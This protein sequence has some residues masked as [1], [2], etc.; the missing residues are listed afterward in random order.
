MKSS[1]LGAIGAFVALVLVVLAW[2]SLYVVGQ[3]Q[4]ALP[5][6]LGEPLQPKLE[7]GL[8]AKV[9][10]TDNIVFVDKRILDLDTPTLEVIAYDKKRLVVDAFTR[11]RVTDPLAFYQNYRL[12]DVAESRMNDIINSAVRSV[13]AQAPFVDVVRTRRNELMARIKSEVNKQMSPNGI[14]IVD[15]RIRRADLPDA[16]SQAVFERMKT[17][18]AQEA[19]QYR[20]E[21][22]QEYQRLRAEADR[23]VS[24]LLG[25]ANG[26][27]ANIRGDADAQRTHIF[28]DAYGRDT[29]FFTFYRSLQAYT[30][31]LKAGQTRFVLR[32][33]SEFFRYLFPKAEAAP[34]APAPTVPSAP[35]Q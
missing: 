7:P 8:Y 26:A 29:E 22:L 12:Q 19:A 6:R 16:N 17:E 13:L 27:A 23:Q 34:A 32:P 30:D 10:F 33:D 24:R 21:G 15:V 1:A 4:F 9:P 3:T 28:A 25:Q 2:S 5:I 31:S 14:E 35:A 11:Y 18:R 20:A